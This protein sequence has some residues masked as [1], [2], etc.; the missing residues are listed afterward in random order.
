MH[1]V[2][3]SPRAEKDLESLPKQIQ[4]R[5][6]KKL[7][8]NAKLENPLVRSEPLVNLPPSTHRFCIGDYRVSFYIREQI[9]YIERIETRGGAFKRH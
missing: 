8:E 3:F 9:I 2:V 4:K 7:K 5:I 6:D 1:F